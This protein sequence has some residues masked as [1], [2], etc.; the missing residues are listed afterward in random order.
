MHTLCCQRSVESIMV[1]RIEYLALSKDVDVNK[2]TSSCHRTPLQLLFHYNRGNTI[3]PCLQALL[4]RKSVDLDVTDEAGNTVLS[5]ACFHRR[6]GK[7]FLKLVALLIINGVDV[8]KTNN[9]GCNAIL[10]LCSRLE[11]KSNVPDLLEI[12]R[13]LIN[14]GADL[15]VQCKD[16]SNVLTALATNYFD[17]PDFYTVLR[18]LI[19]NGANVNSVNLNKQNVLSIIC[20]KYKGD[21][22]VDIV[23]FLLKC[24]IQTTNN[25]SGYDLVDLLIRKRG[26]SKDSEIVRMIQG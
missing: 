12:V 11:S 13:A 23:Q 22:F 20:D 8:N 14:A 16:G 25:R 15:K 9:R 7:K 3:F 26:F 6:D 1:H 17:H 24:G 21:E 4:K 19:Q 18:L 5:V 10:L 2:T